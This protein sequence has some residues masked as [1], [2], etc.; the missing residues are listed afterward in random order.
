MR[1]DTDE[2]DEIWIDIGGEG[3][4]SQ[5]SKEARD[6]RGSASSAPRPKIDLLWHSLGQLT[7]RFGNHFTRTHFA[8]SG[9]LSFPVV[10]CTVAGVG[11]PPVASHEIV[12]PRGPRRILVH[13]PV[14]IG[15]TKR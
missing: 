5:D 13:G 2:L 11:P 9:R 14:P 15:D 3:L 7:A 6:D 8:E 4:T 10:P 12:K 1:H